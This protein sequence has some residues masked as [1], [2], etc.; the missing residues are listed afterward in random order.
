MHRMFNG[1]LSDVISRD[2]HVSETGN[3]NKN[4]NNNNN[5]NNG[6]GGDSCIERFGDHSIPDVAGTVGEFERHVT[7][8][9][10]HVLRMRDPTAVT[11]SPRDTL[12]CRQCDQGLT[13]DIEALTS[14]SYSAGIIVVEDW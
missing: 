6:G 10:N 14:V 8:Y 9:R 5:N 3:R 12:P 4:N 2:G 7:H 13:T 1:I 11:S